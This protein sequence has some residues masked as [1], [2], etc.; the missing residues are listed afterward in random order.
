MSN[1]CTCTMA[2][3]ELGHRENCPMSQIILEENLRIAEL[4]E[5][6]EFLQTKLDE[7]NETIEKLTLS[8]QKLK[9]GLAKVEAMYDEK[10]AR[11]AELKQ[12][13][14]DEIAKHGADAET[15]ERLPLTADGVRVVPGVDVYGYN[16]NG[17]V[18]PHMVGMCC[19]DSTDGNGDGIEWDIEQP[20][21]N[22]WYLPN[23]KATYSTREAAEAAK[24]GSDCVPL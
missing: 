6:V 13:T 17:E 24:G 5:N 10:V 12:M 11:V 7:A 1:H 2:Q 22:E 18:E 20:Q 16:V 23:F 15:V 21:N 8:N 9:D 19:V 14:L 4:E 3:I